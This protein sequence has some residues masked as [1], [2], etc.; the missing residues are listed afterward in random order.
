M[1]FGGVHYPGLVAAIDRTLQ[2]WR[3]PAVW[4]QV[5][6]NGMKADFSW[7]RSGAAYAGLYRELLG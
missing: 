2:L 6:R 5:Q 1:Q 7:T 4:R 3:D